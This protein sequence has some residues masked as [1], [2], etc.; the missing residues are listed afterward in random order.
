MGNPSPCRMWCTTSSFPKFLASCFPSLMMAARPTLPPAWRRAPLLQYI[1]IRSTQFWF[2]II[3]LK[4]Y[5]FKLIKTIPYPIR[6][7]WSDSLVSIEAVGGQSRGSRCNQ[8]T[9]LQ[10]FPQTCWRIHYPLPCMPPQLRSV[11]FHTDPNIQGTS[12]REKLQDSKR[13]SASPPV[14]PILQSCRQW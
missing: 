5:I 9:L 12:D 1:W 4:M 3:Y 13:I 14:S 7:E 2:V 6:K 8:D 10:I 11:V